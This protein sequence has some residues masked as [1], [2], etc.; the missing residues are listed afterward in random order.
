MEKHQTSETI[1]K[2]FKKNF[3]DTFI[4]DN[5]KN[6]NY[7][8][9]QF[10]V[11]VLS[12]QSNLKKFGLKKGD[13][14]CC[15]LENS[16]DFVVLY[17][18]SLLHNV[19]VVPVDP[20]KG[21][22]EIK[23]ILEE[24]QPQIIF[25][26]KKNQDYEKSVVLNELVLKNKNNYEKKINFT[27]FDNVDYNNLFLITFTSGST[28]KSK[29][30]LHSFNDLFLSSFAF[31]K[32]FE[33]NE[34]NIFFHNLPMTY[35]AGILNLI[36]LPFFSESK[37]VLANKFNFSEVI[38]FWDLPIKYNVNSFWFIPT[39][40]ELL[41]R[42]DRGKTGINYT[43]NNKIIGCVGTAPLNLQSKKIFEEKYQINLY[44]SYGLSETLFVTTNSPLEK[45][46]FTVGKSLDGVDLTF[47]ENEI[48]IKTPW[49]FFRYFFKKRDN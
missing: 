13:L 15:L 27:A 34:R 4:F 48:M 3:N 18:A 21:E 43:K 30:V 36:F 44:E 23:T 11:D 26:D 46:N 17:F 10:L 19:V 12:L 14:I 16:Y 20:L 33:F 28:G 22:N 41:I 39:I 38:N 9:G 35:M 7:T 29:G 2:I 45:K 8:Y 37:I 5:F 49:N 24:I 32:K 6:K 1:K 31:A 40:I 47:A 42:L 25:I